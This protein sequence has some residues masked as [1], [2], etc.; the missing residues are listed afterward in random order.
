MLLWSSKYLLWIKQNQIYKPYAVLTDLDIHTSTLFHNNS[1]HTFSL[2]ASDW[3]VNNIFFR[4]FRSFGSRRSPNTLKFLWS[5]DMYAAELVS[6]PL[7]FPKIW[8]V[9]TLFDIWSIFLLNNK[10]SHCKTE[11]VKTDQNYDGVIWFRLG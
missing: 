1:F 6:E 10:S 8:H 4:R 2:R 7:G 9:L 11:T 3:S 5:H